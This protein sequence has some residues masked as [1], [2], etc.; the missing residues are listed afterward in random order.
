MSSSVKGRFSRAQEILRTE[1]L[2]AL[3]GKTPRYLLWKLGR[4]GRYLF[5]Y[6]VCYLYE[7]TMKERNEADYLPRLPDFTLKIISTNEEADEV[8]RDGF[9]D[10]RRMWKRA[11]HA[12]DH[13]GVAFCVFVGPELAHIGWVATNKKAKDTFDTLPYRVDFA[14]AQA[15]TGGTWTRPKYRGNG[16]MN[17]I[18]FKR[19]QYLRA[20]GIKTSRNAVETDNTASQK[21]HARFGPRV[22]AEARYLRV[23]R[24]YLKTE[25]PVAAGAPAGPAG[26]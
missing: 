22:L 19:F 11:G 3:F 10:I 23:I 5:E 21:S 14:S 2:T 18:C 9:Q 4:L 16:L 26:S 20:S 12:L 1:G 24:W 25:K 7:H 17:Y 15:C 8:A 13:G 6:R